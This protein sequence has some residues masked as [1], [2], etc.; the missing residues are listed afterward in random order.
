VTRLTLINQRTL[1]ERAI[2][3][4]LRLAFLKRQTVA[5]LAALAALDVSAGY[6]GALCYVTSESRVYSLNLYSGA[7]NAPP[8]IVAPTTPPARGP[9]ARWIRSTSAVNWGPNS[10]APLAARPAGFCL[11]VDFFRG[12]GGTDEGMLKVLAAKPSILL[13][14]ESSKTNPASCGYPGA[15]YE[16]VHTYSVWAISENDR[17]G[18]WSSWGDPVNGDVT[19]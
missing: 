17:G 19:R 9:G 1:I 2:L 8:A 18:P 5:D 7:A 4:T 13:V 14:W 15:Y 11:E 16:F 12:R 6:D 10:G 3:D